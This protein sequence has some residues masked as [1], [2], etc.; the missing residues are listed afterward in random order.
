[1][2]VNLRGMLRNMLQLPELLRFDVID[3]LIWL[4]MYFKE[5]LFA[6]T[7]KSNSSLT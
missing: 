3:G 2:V 1:M 6:Q 7:R 4:G 5:N